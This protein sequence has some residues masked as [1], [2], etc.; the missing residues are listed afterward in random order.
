V[1]GYQL[2]A[3]EHYDTQS[4]MLE[5]SF[6][7]LKLSVEVLT[8]RPYSPGNYH[9]LDHSVSCFHFHTGKEVQC[10]VQNWLHNQ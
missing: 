8:N 10:T 4:H 6:N 5:Y 9:V 7:S 1:R 3:W 2:A